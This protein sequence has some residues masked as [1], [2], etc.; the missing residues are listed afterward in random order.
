MMASRLVLAL[1]LTIGLLAD[2][3]ADAQPVTKM[4]RIGLLGSAPT[5]TPHRPLPTWLNSFL[6]GLRERGWV[7]GQNVAFEFP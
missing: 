3:P 2:L 1:T 4:A 6:E 7:E 5:P